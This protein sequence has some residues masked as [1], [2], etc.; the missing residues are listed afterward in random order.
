MYVSRKCWEK[1]SAGFGLFFFLR[2]DFSQVLEG[3][4]SRQFGVCLEEPALEGERRERKEGW[5]L[6]SVV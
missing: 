6:T 5:K 3:E 4:V 2:R 1:R